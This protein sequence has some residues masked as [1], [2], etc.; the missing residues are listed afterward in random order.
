MSNLYMHP[1]PILAIME[2][3]DKTIE[4]GKN[5]TT[6]YAIIAACVM[7]IIIIGAFVLYASTSSQGFSEL[8]FENHEE[9][10]RMVNAGEEIRFGFTLASHEKMPVTYNYNVT[11]DGRMVEEGDLTLQPEENKTLNVTIIPQNSSLVP[12][13]VSRLATFSARVNQNGEV[14]L[15]LNDG[16]ESFVAMNLKEAKIPDWNF[17]KVERVGSRDDLKPTEYNSISSLGYS[18]RRDRYLIEDAGQLKTLNY[19]LNVTEY[20]YRF[21]KVAINVTS[22]K[23]LKFMAR[24]DGTEEW[25]DSRE[26]KGNPYEIHFWIVVEESPEKLLAS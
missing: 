24:E 22:E 5:K 19:S 25:T 10:P 14:R 6:V 21:E 7:G 2:G 12:F 16:T 17:T 15:S 3:N 13:D 23:Q 18:V 26:E 8:Y 9:L 4:T 20:R 11:F 1:V